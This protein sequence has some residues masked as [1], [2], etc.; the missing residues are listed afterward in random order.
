MK[1]QMFEENYDDIHIPEQLSQAVWEGIEKGKKIRRKQCR[2]RIGITMGSV[3]AVFSIF[4]NP[5][6]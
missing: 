2:K 5:Y 6:P 3:A 1:N 4:F